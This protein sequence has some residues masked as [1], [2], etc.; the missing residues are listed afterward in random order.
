MVVSDKEKKRKLRKASFDQKFVE[1]AP[2]VI[3]CCGDLLSWRNTREHV[4]E[5]TR[6]GDIQFNEECERAL[7]ERISQSY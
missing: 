3:V 2:I 6:N 1:D 7:M 4:Q 5:I